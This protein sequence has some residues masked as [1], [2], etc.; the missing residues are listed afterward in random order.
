MD[1]LAQFQLGHRRDHHIAVYRR[2]QHLPLPGCLRALRLRRLQL[3]GAQRKTGHGRINC[4]Q[5]G[6]RQ[7]KSW[8]NRDINIPFKLPQVHIQNATLAGGVAVGTCAD[9]NIGPYG[10]MLIG[11]VAG[12]ISTLGFKYLSVSSK[13]EQAWKV[14]KSNRLWLFFSERK[15]KKQ[16]KN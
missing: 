5:R 15:Q 10:A 3:S 1:V 12:T 7:S 9:M 2:H 8:G 6:P 14:W 11:L 16:W 13:S 4:T